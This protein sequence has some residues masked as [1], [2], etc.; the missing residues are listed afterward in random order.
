M[1]TPVENNQ[2]VSDEPAQP[3]W[4]FRTGFIVFV[5]SFCAPALIPLVASSDL[6]VEMKASLS[7]LLALG[8][9]EIGALIA[10]AIMGKPGFN[11]MK[12]RIFAVFG[13]YGPPKEVGLMRYRIGLVMFVVPLLFGFL[14][15]Y[16][17]H[18]ISSYQD[19]DVSVSVALDVMLIASLFV[20]GGNFWDKIRG[21]FSH[22]AKMLFP[23]ESKPAAQ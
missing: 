4:R 22:P 13:K 9:P 8:I 7:G 10:V 2:T 16:L 11:E 12:R 20:L 14:E 5:V 19:Q 18:F 17:E 6:S 23:G 15:P 1:N 21:L 3:G